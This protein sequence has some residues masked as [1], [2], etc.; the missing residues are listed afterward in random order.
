MERRKQPLLWKRGRATFPQRL[1][2][3]DSSP[4]S[5]IRLGLR[6]D[7]AADL[8]GRDDGVEGPGDNLA[9]AC[10]LWMVDQSAFQQFGVRENDAELI[11][12]SMEQ[13]SQIVGGGARRVLSWQR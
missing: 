13:P 10:P 4:F 1:W 11:V 5:R 7:G 2:K 6:R 12:E 9:G 8:L 3:R